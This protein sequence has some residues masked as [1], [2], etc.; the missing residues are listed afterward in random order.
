MAKEGHGGA[1]AIIAAVVVK[2]RMW[3]QLLAILPPVHR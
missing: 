2:N 3:S 1:K